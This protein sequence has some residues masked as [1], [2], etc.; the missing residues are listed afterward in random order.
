MLISNR[1]KKNDRCHEK[2]TE[3]PR[4]SIEYL[5]YYKLL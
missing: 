5:V 1:D 3:P 4:W 2:K